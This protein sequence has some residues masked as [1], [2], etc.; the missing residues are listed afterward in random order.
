MIMKKAYLIFILLAIARQSFAQCILGNCSTGK[1]SFNYGWCLYNGEFKNGKPDGQGTMKYDDHSY[2][3]TF[4][5]GLEDG[6]GIYT[7]KDGTSEKVQY[8][9]GVKIVIAL[10]KIATAD[11]KPLVAQDKNCL[12]GDCVTGFGTYQYPSGNKYTG[13]FNDYKREGKGVF[14]FTNGDKFDGIFHDNEKVNGTYSFSTG[15]KY[16]GTY[17]SRGIEYNG[18]ITSV[19][20]MSIPYVNGKPIIPPAPKIAINTSNSGGQNSGPRERIKTTCSVCFGTGKTSRTEDWSNYGGAQGGNREYRS[21]ARVY[22]SCYRCG[23]SG[24]N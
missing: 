10:Q 19:A 3:G 6:E 18:M 17:D 2:T 15:A 20:G 5:K 8:Q 13:N 11:Y 21:T 22:T 1:G 14:Y 24:V 4:A 12:S 7:N 16:K 23:G 9:A